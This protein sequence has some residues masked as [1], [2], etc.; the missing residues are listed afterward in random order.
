MRRARRLI[1]SHVAG[2]CLQEVLTRNR[3]EM[4]W[5]SLAA[6]VSQPKTTGRCDQTPG[7]AEIGSGR[8][9]GSSAPQDAFS[10]RGCD[11]LFSRRRDNWY[12]EAQQLGRRSVPCADGNE[13]RQRSLT[14][15]ESP[16]SNYPAMPDFNK[17]QQEIEIGKFH[18]PRPSK[19]KKDPEFSTYPAC[20]AYSPH[21]L[22]AARERYRWRRTWQ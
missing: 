21:R 3:L 9:R 14:R 17:S 10:S 20:A 6:T 22:G 18:S 11:S 13:H 7:E 16:V 19:R 8:D 1:G 4:P 15:F 5:E 12:R 2:C